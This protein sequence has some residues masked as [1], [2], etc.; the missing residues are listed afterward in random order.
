MDCIP[1]G[2][3]G[4]RDLSTLHGCCALM[5]LAFDSS[6]N[7]F[8]RYSYLSKSSSIFKIIVHLTL[9][10]RKKNVLKNYA[11]SLFLMTNVYSFNF[12]CRLQKHR[13]LPA[14]AISGDFYRHG[15]NKILYHL[16]VTQ[17]RRQGICLLVAATTAAT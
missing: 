10:Y 6:R 13:I 16:H 9:N 4:F 14:F 2:N 12:C 5:L 8:T 7:E 15:C 11:T 17:N 3:S 1:S